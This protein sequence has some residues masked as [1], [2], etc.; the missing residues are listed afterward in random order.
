MKSVAERKN[1]ALKKRINID[2][3]TSF[4][5]EYFEGG[6]ELKEKIFNSY[7]AMEQFHKRQS[8]FMYLDINR[9]ALVD[10]TW[11]KFIQLRSP[12]VFEKEIEFI[13]RVFNE[14]VEVENLQ[15]SNNEE[16]NLQK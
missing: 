8:D 14:K 9:Y 12:F 6:S 3:A 7:K 15:N 5:L 2:N 11:H 16:K 4:K 13:N 1:M 10:K